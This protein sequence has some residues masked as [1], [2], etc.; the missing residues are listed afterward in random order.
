[1]GTVGKKLRVR[2]A[3]ENYMSFMDKVRPFH[4]QYGID[5]IILSG[6]IRRGKEI[7][8]GDIDLILVTT[9]GNIHPDF[10]AFLSSIGFELD[11]SGDKLIRALT[12]ERVQFD[13]YACTEEES[14]FMS[15]Y[16]TGPSEFNIGMRSQAKKLGYKL[17][18]KSMIQQS[19]GEEMKVSSETEIFNMLGCNYIPAK[20]R[21]NWFKDSKIFKLKEEK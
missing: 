9:D 6:S 12:S 1:M 14:F 16:L 11:A 8:I 13:F 4:V 18:Q 15:C 17:N 21:I 2:T 19:S 5:N 10:P 7:N 20:D 3:L